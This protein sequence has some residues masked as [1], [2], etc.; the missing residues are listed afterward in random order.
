M[1]HGTLVR[2]PPV[3][4]AAFQTATE[5]VLA[6]YRALGWNPATH[7]LDPTRVRMNS[8]TW[9]RY[10][11]ILVRR[12]GLPGGFAWMN[13][14]PS[15]S[16]GA[17]VQRSQL[18]IEDGWLQFAGDDQAPPVARSARVES[19]GAFGRPVPGRRIRR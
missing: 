14:G 7:R 3:N 15:G 6:F 16:G 10:V 19:P 1:V 17:D 9:K 4:P 11:G 2:V 12:H 8:D 5:F 13:Y 18:V